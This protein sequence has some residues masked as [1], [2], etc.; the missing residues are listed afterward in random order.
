[1]QLDEDA[2]NLIKAVA[3]VRGQTMGDIVY[4]L[5]MGAA[6]GESPQMD[7]L[8]IQMSSLYDVVTAPYIPESGI[9]TDE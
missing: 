6:G 9:D 4:M 3:K 5:V 2:A 8:K 1:M 7:R